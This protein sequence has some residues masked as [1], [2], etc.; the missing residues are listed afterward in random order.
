MPPAAAEGGKGG[1]L[2]GPGTCVGLG[3][4]KGFGRRRRRGWRRTPCEARGADRGGS[5]Q[6]GWLATRP[7]HLALALELLVQLYNSADELALAV[8]PILA[9]AR[10]Q[11]VRPARQPSDNARQ[12]TARQIVRTDGTVAAAAAAAYQ[13]TGSATAT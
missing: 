11:L 3:W 5:S 4:G 10:C 6:H 7:W 13:A 12:A 9:A 8:L 1:E 2:G